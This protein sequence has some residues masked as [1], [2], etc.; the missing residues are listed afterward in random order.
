MKIFANVI[1][2]IALFV[3]AVFLVSVLT[4]GKIA[5]IQEEASKYI[6]ENT[7]IRCSECEYLN[8]DS[9]FKD[10]MWCNRLYR[11]TTQNWYCADAKRIKNKEGN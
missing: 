4:A 3:I 9:P 5:D 2:L 1:C 8:N 6:Y 7:P 11:G 10:E